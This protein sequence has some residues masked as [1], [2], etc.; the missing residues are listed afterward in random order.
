MG[1]GDGV[2]LAQFPHY[3]L[4][5]SGNFDNSKYGLKC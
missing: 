2:T 4:A 5:V 1:G 3:E